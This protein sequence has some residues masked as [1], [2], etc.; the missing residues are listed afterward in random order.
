MALP[1]RLFP[2]ARQDIV[3]TADYIAHDSLDAAL[4]FLDAAE[5][6]FDQLTMM[7]ELGACCGFKRADALETRVWPISGFRN[8]LVFYRV[9][10][11]RLEIIRV[12]HGA[13]DYQSLLSAE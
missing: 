5:N 4:R 1:L 7:P 13:Q 3:E 11:A 6:T 8:Y 12:L 2:L 10:H 9:H